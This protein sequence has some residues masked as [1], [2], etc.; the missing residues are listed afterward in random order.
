MDDNMFTR[1]IKSAMKA[2]QWNGNTKQN[3]K[4]LLFK[5]KKEE[6]RAKQ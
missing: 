3:I 4:L 1:L 2:A 6:R 5:E